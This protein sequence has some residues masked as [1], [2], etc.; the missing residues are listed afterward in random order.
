MTRSSEKV[1]MEY[2]GEILRKTPEGKFKKYWFC[3][4]G[5][6]LYCYRKRDDERHK[7][8]HSLVGV[9]INSESDEVIHHNSKTT[10]FYPFKLIFPPNKCRTYYL[11]TRGQ[12]DKWVE[13]I[14]DAI[15]YAN[16]EDF[17]EIKVI[18]LL[19]L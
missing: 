2:E 5:K 16:L 7:G 17:Y 11:L 8:M 4:L 6:E 10:T 15:G 1:F 19:S 14:K 3:L 13:V 9:F 18:L 12:R